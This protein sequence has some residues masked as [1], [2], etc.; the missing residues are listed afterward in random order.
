MAEQQQLNVVSAAYPAPPPFYKHFTPENLRRLEEL[1]T[2]PEHIGG[3]GSSPT[4]VSQLPPELRYLVPP[5][6][7]TEGTYRSFGDSYNVYIPLALSTLGF[8]AD[9]LLLCLHSGRR[10]ST[11]LGRTGHRA[12]LPVGSRCVRSRLRRRHKVRV[13]A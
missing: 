6:P 2:E 7:P 4:P 12:A 10:V 11:V 8:F 3:E 9:A 1:R 5:R 13:D